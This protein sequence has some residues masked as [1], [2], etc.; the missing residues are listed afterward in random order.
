[1]SRSI[2]SENAAA[3]ES[4]AVSPVVLCRLDLST[5]V[6][7]QDG[8]G[9]ISFSGNEYSGLAG[10]GTVDTIREAESFV[11]APINL[12]LSGLTATHIT[13]ALDAA[14]YGDVVTLYFGHLDENGDLI[15]TPWVPF[16]GY[17]SHASADLTGGELKVTYTVHHVLDNLRR[18]SGRRFS[19]EDQTDEFAGD[20]GFSFVHKMP[21]LTLQ[22]GGRPALGRI[23]FS[24]RAPPSDGPITRA[25]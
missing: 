9:I 2:G 12:T 10:Y 22:W 24:G 1:M 21:D 25:R 19:D 23:I 13:E 15:A 11:P 4:A 6:Y 17:F 20:T 18:K 5:P 16:R 7:V 14:N 3:T 8:V